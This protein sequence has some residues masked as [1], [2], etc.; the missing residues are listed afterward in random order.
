MESSSSA[1]SGF[2]YGTLAR[3]LRALPLLLLLP[4]TIAIAD[5]PLPPADGRS[6]GTAQEAFEAIVI[7]SGLARR[8]WRE[9]REVAVAF[10][11]LPDGAWRATSVHEG[12][13]WTSSIPYHEVPPQAIEIASAHTHGQPSLAG[14]GGRIY[15]LDFSRVDRD[16]ALHNFA[17]T[18][19]RIAT[20][21]L[22]TSRMQVRRLSVR[23][24]FD[25]ETD[26]IHVFDRTE[27]IASLEIPPMADAP[28]A[29]ALVQSAG[30]PVH[31]PGGVVRQEAA[32]REK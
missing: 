13:E 12:D 11:R 1:S 10:Y 31:T 19:G 30:L 22:V 9:N 15:G 24:G 3:L 21:F 2:R 23:K 27:T 14:D 25:P 6:F 8:A 32:K 7:D 17:L 26:S 4:S 20:H 5:P 28:L 16:N 29:T 18:R